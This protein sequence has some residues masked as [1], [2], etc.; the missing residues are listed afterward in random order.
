MLTPPRRRRA[1]RL[2][3]FG[4]GGGASPGAA[5]AAGTAASA[6]R[7]E[8]RIAELMRTLQA[9][10]QRLGATSGGAGAGSRPG[11]AGG[12]MH[13]SGGT[14]ASA[15]RPGSPGG[16]SSGAPGGAFGTGARAG[17]FCLA[18]VQG[19][20]GDCGAA[21]AGLLPV[22]RS[23]KAPPCTAQTPDSAAAV[24]ALRQE[25]ARYQ[26]GRAPDA[27]PACGRL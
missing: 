21:T 15:W 7:Y 13:G 26:V 5:A 23:P 18:G 3:G 17:C 16:A 22:R 8:S 9:Y 27:R 24:D 4:T 6:A 12:A 1:T 2:P 20:T 19:G 10:E 14:A 25:V 11:T